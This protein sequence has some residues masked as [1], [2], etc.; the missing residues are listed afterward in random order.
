MNQL[1]QWNMYN[2][3]VS[4]IKLPKWE[5]DEKGN[6]VQKNSWSEVATEEWQRYL[7]SQKT[8]LPVFIQSSVSLWQELQAENAPLRAMLNGK[9]VS[10]S[11]KLY[12]DFILREIKAEGEEFQEAKIVGRVL[13]KY[14]LGIADS[15][16][17]FRI[18][19]MIHDG[20]L[21]AVTAG[22]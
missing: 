18:E 6:I 19:E 14:Q 13:G 3:Q 2:V 12:D 1:N 20:K 9:L 22:D 4:I 5:A 11:E 8:A 7:S 15:W 17:A 10:T 21:E 16:V